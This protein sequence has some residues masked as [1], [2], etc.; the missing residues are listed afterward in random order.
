MEFGLFDHMD[1]GA[2]TVAEDFEHRLRLAEAGEALGFTRFHATEHHGTPLSVAPSPSLLMAALAQRTRRLRFGPLVWNLPLYNPLRLAEE[3][4]MLDQISGGRLEMGVG[5]GAS[6][7]ELRLHNIA[8]EEAEPRFEEALEL[9]LL[10]LRGEGGQVDFSGRFFRA[11]GLP[12]VIGP[13][14]AP[15]PP[16]WYGVTRAATVARIAPHRM[17]IV[18]SHD[19]TAARPITDAYRALLAPG[20]AEPLMGINRHAVVAESDAA[21]LALGRRAYAA[22]HRS[23]THLWRLKGGAPHTLMFPPDFDALLASGKALAGSPASVRAQLAAQIRDSGCNYVLAR[24]AFG[25]MRAE[26]SLASQALFAREVMGEF[27]PLHCAG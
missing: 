7:I 15:H 27:A 11:E 21:A 13:V 4:A 18:T 26:E 20:Q 2:G 3:I 24:F 1:H 12:V 25:D 22:W 5:R 16:L 14:Q 17:N 19:A 9:I 10:I 23:F 6:P 8:P